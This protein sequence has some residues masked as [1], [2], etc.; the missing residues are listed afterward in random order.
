MPF[1]VYSQAGAD[2][3]FATAAQ[4]D[5]A[6]AAVQPVPYSLRA[7]HP[8]PAQLCGTN[9]TLLK[10]QT[11][12]MPFVAPA[13]MVATGVTMFSQAATS[14]TTSIR[15]ALYHLGTSPFSTDPA[16][17]ATM[18]LLAR[19]ASDTTIFTSADTKYVRSFS[20]TGG[21]PTS[22]RLV[23]GERYAIALQIL[24][25]TMG[26]I[27]GPASFRYTLGQRALNVCLNTPTAL[28]PPPEGLY[29]SVDPGSISSTYNAGFFSELVVNPSSTLARPTRTAVIGDSF[30]GYS[31][32]LGWG[33]AQGG[34]NVYYA[35]HDS[36]GGATV[37]T[38][39]SGQ[40]AGVSTTQP[41]CVIM[42]AGVNDIAVDSASTATMQARYTA[43]LDALLAIPSVETVVV[44][45]PPPST[46]IT[47][48]QIAVLS[49]V[50]AWLLALN[51]AG[52]VV[53][54]TGMAMSTGDGTTSD[55]AKRV[56]GVHPNAAG[57]QAMGDALGG[58]LAAL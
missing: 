19:T 17:P 57:M 14:G 42:H 55:A 13:D 32:W 34:A 15:F 46:Y 36:L 51:R 6:E 41:N 29:P 56:D 24:G 54:D 49:E 8:I 26:T 18:W 22:V 9:V 45:T 30:T 20:A 3:A 23:R 43:A 37:P 21:Y 27:P 47:G 11:L 40:L 38:V 4:G 48:G 7:F 16:P 1:D 50:R 31:K 12:F 28:N 44:C 10:D 35:R 52:V 5:L 53:A 25:G 33:N 39:I 58:V 2:A